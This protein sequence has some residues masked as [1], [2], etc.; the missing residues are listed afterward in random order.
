M[1][2][3]ENKVTNFSIDDLFKDPEED[4]KPQDEQKPAQEPSEMTKEMSKR[5]NEVRAKTERETRDAMAKELGYDNY[6]AMKKANEKQ[7]LR[8]AG[9]DDAEIEPIVQ[10][11]VEKRFAEDPRMKRLEEY[12]QRDKANFVNEQLKEVNKLTGLNYKDV[13]ELPQ[14]VLTMWEK[15]GNLKQAYLAT[16]GE[17][18]L[19][20]SLA[21]KQNGSLAHLANPG[22]TGVGVKERPLTA[23]EKDIWRMVNPDITDE[24]LSKK[25][26][27][28]S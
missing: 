26:M 14:E 22:S 25:T 5:I 3:N 11:L 12:E 15:T 21:G 1:D 16:Q 8:D 4:L 9:L 2:E 24:E 28:V 6:E 7:V 23:E 27:P 19:T 18:L 17:T 13:S 20:K 10:K